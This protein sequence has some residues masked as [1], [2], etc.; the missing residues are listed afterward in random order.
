MGSSFSLSGTMV[1]ARCLCCPTVFCRPPCSAC[2]YVLS[3]EKAALWGRIPSRCSRNHRNDKVGPAG[4]SSQQPECVHFP[5][6]DKHRRC[7]YT[8]PHHPAIHLNR[9]TTFC[10]PSPR[11]ARPATQAWGGS[12]DRPQGGRTP[13]HAEDG[14]LRKRCGKGRASGPGRS[15]VVQGTAVP[16]TRFTPHLRVANGFAVVPT[17]HP[18]PSG[19]LP[20]STATASNPSKGERAISRSGDG[21]DVQQKKPDQRKLIGNWNAAATYSPG[22]SPAKYHRRAEA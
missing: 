16:R 5:V 4:S 14:P 20:I 11:P 2:V 22:P 7:W 17:G 12:T 21:P 10:P 18:L 19:A 1:C 6:D 13:P 9:S 8:C 15:I 3:T